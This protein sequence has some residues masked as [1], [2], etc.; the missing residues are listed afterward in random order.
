MS[1]STDPSCLDS[2]FT[3]RRI[4]I[5]GASERGMYPAGILRNLLDYGYSG[6]I[7]PVN[8]K[9][10]TVFGLLCYLDVTQTPQR[11]D[12]AILTIPRRAVLPTLR[13]CLTVG[14][15]AALIITA[16]RHRRRG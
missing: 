4:A 5:V 3:P 6:D 1:K 2:F 7:Y 8:P 15:P 9:R 11:A 14:I 16:G 10:Q 13:Q 12:V